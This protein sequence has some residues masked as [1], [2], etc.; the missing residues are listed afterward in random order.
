MKITGG[1][2]EEKT[3]SSSLS[4]KL[5]ARLRLHVDPSIGL[6][7]KVVERYTFL[8]CGDKFKGVYSADRIPLRLAARPSFTIIVNLELMEERGRESGGHFVTV[9]GGE[10][11]IYYIDPYGLPSAVPQVNRF[12]E[13][14]RRPIYQNFRQIQDLDSIY[15]GMYAI[16]FARFFDREKSPFKMSFLRSNLK[17]NDRRCV[18]YL[19]RMIKIK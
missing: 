19:R 3:S 6:S 15:C 12:L 8:I 13:L 1:E 16:L 5:A 2:G 14:C 10:E 18:E 7:N 4:A 9:V 11:E 17:R